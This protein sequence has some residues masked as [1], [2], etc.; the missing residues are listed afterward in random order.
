ME[1]ATTRD[2]ER[3]ALYENSKLPHI[4]NTERLDQLWM[5]LA[6]ALP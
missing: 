3:D 5:S 2:K 4:P 6:D 1:W